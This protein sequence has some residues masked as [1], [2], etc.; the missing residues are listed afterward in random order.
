MQSLTE[1]SL[2]Q[3]RVL[4]SIASWYKNPDKSSLTIG[5]YAGTGKTTLIA[6]L[7]KLLHK[8]QPKTRVAFVSFTGKASQVLQ[9][10]LTQFQALFEQDSCGTIHSL[11]YHPKI[12]STGRINGWYPVKD[13]KYDLIIVDEA[14]M[15][16]S[17]IWNDLNRFKVPIIAVGDHGQLPPVGDTFS[18][19]ER[20]DLVLER[21]HRQA[22][23]SAII[24]MATMAR[25]NGQIPVQDFAPYAR[26]LAPDSPEAYDLFERAVNGN[27]TMILCARNKTRIAL[28]N[29]IRAQ[30]FFEDPNPQIN[31]TLICLKNYYD[32]TDGPIYNGMVGYLKK[33]TPYKEHWYDVIVD[34]PVEN[35]V[36]EGKIT[37]HQFNQEQV[38]HKHDKI[39]PKKIGERFDF[40]Y[41]LTVHKAQGSQAETVLVYEESAQMWMKDNYAKWLYTAITRASSN[42]FLIA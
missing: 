5:G 21:I 37:K 35:K 39:P 41:A 15:V 18:L 6:I 30:K 38:I 16:S 20:P 10:K 11:I 42:I 2:D 33:I 4:Q 34:F 26:K 31:D 17:D 8:H 14:S 27:D 36:F 32:N 29:Q 12:D 23:G 13:I 22:E 9:N 40:G 24:Q 28:N 1:L 19:M 7:R 3:K 25:L